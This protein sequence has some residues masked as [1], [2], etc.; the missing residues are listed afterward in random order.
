LPV[1][2]VD[3]FPKVA[4]T[5]R[6]LLTVTVQLVAA[7]PETARRFRERRDQRVEHRLGEG[8]LFGGR[9]IGFHQPLQRDSASLQRLGAGR[10]GRTTPARVGLK[11]QYLCVERAHR[12]SLD[13]TTVGREGRTQHSRQ[14]Y[15]HC[16]CRSGPTL[17]AP[18]KYVRVHLVP[19]IANEL[20]PDAGDASPSGLPSPGGGR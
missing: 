1:V 3:D 18:T 8:E 11:L 16:K 13:G 19:T 17:G 12:V 15:R 20:N 2:L 7:P 4:L 14:G 6:S 5:V 10:R 9:W